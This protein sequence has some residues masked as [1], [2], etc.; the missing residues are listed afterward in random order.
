M[1]EEKDNDEEVLLGMVSH[2]LSFILSEF[3]KYGYLL[4]FEKDLSDLKGLVMADSMAEDDYEILDDVSDPAVKLLLKSSEKV[5]QCSSTYLLI[6]GLDQMDVLEDN[7]AHQHASN[8]YHFY[9]EEPNGTNYTDLL[10]ESCQIYFSIMHLIYH[11]C[12]QLTLKQVDLPDELFDDFYMDFLDVLDGNLIT[13][14][15]NVQLLYDL[16]VLLNEDMQ[17]MQQFR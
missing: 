8:N 13:K 12:C 1:K 10:E 14:D 11:T 7:D 17:E 6:N 4:A 5:M 15:K 9:I 16:I 2:I 3:C